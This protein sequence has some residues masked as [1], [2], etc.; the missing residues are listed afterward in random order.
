MDQDGNYLR[1]KIAVNN[2]FLH[3]PYILRIE[4]GEGGGGYRVKQFGNDQL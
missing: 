2:H 3:S 1:V 4:M